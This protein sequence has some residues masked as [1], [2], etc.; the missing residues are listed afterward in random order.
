M[1]WSAFCALFPLVT[2]GLACSLVCPAVGDAAT[3][4]EDPPSE[5][6]TVLVKKAKRA[7]KSG[8]LADAYVF[9]SQASA[10]MPR[11]RSY[12]SHAAALKIRGAAQIKSA[13]APLASLSDSV[14]QGVTDGEVHHAGIPSDLLFDSV[15]AREIAQTRQLAS[16]PKLS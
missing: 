6:A 12:R 5:L 8:D 1:R 15:T 7:E 4:T 3:F 11:N 14:A 2:L 10:L 13:S 16:P 9:Y